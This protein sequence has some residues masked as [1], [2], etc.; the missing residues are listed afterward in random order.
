[1]RFVLACKI[2]V[3]EDRAVSITL[4]EDSGN[5]D[6]ILAD[7]VH[8]IDLMEEISRCVNTVKLWRG[9]S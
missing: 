3:A 4:Y 1:M 8:A 2:L 5:L 7:N 6:I 9:V